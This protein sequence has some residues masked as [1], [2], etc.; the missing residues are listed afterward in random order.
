MSGSLLFSGSLLEFMQTIL[1][2]E[3]LFQALESRPLVSVAPILRARLVDLQ[4][5]IATALPAVL[6]DQV[7]RHREQVKGEGARH[8]HA[9]HEG[10]L[11]PSRHGKADLVVSW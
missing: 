1:R 6:D 10:V 2:N 9:D 5:D 7:G 8:H 4:F 11:V 3:G